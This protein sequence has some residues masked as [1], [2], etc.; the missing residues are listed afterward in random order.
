M[1]GVSTTTVGSWTPGGAAARR[2]ASSLRGYSCTGRM[3]WV[4]KD[5]GNTWV[6]A[7][8]LAMT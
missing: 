7:R 1:P 8:R 5:S 6:M 2:A 3:R 4:A